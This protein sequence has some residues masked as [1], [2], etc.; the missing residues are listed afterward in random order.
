MSKLISEITQFKQKSTDYLQSKAKN[1]L[2]QIVQQNGNY[3]K[4][5]ADSDATAAMS[6]LNKLADLKASKNTTIPPYLRFGYLIAETNSGKQLDKIPIPLLL[7]NAETAAVLFDMEH[8]KPDDIPALFQHIALR[9]LLSLQMKVCRFYMIDTDFGSSFSFFSTV[10]NPSLQRELF[11]KSEDINKLMN[12]LQKTVSQANQ[13]YLG[14][15]KNLTDYNSKAGQMAQP[16]HFVFIDDFPNAFTSQSLESLY[17]LIS[18]GNAARAGIHIFINYS[19]K[20][21]A[22]RDFDINRF[23]Q[24][25]ACVNANAKGD[26]SL[27]NWNIKIPLPKYKTVIET[28]LPKN[29]NKIVDFINNMEEEKI[30][31]SLD[32]WIDDLKKQKQIWKDTTENGI[33]VP[34]GFVSP[35]EMFNF[36]LAND[37]D[38]NCNDFFALVA[39]RP[40][41]G[42]TVLLHN[43]IVN[44]CMK[45]ASDELNLYLADFAEGASFSIY[46][47]LPHCKSLMLSNNK[48]YALRMLEHLEKEFK[49]RSHLYQQAQKKFG[50]QVNT[51]TSYRKITGE[52]LPRILLVMD[53]F[54]FLFNSVDMV[55]LT[56]RE[57]LCN[58]IRQW[59]K[60]GISIILCTQDLSGVNF[61]DADSKITYRFAL[62]LLEMD[63]KRVIRN[64]AAMSLTRKGQTIMNNT[65]NG[66]EQMN[67]EFQCAFT[68]RYLEHTNWLAAGYKK[69]FGELPIKYICES[70]TDADITDNIALCQ[71]IENESFT[72]NHNYCDVFVGKPDLLRD[73]HTRIRYRRQQNSNTLMIGEDFGTAINTIA[74]SLIQLQKQSATSSKLYVIDCFNAGDEFQGALNGLADY[75]P[76]NFVLGNAQVIDTIAEELEKRKQANSAGT[77]TEERIVL[78]VLNIQNC[79]DLKPQ[80]GGMMPMPSPAATKLAKIL[81]DGAPLGI[82]CI[83]HSLN[84]NSL[85]GNGNIFDS[86][87]MNN[88]ENK[89][90]LKGADTQTM[91]LGGTKIG[92]VE[93]NN[94][95]IVQN[96]KLDGENYEQCKAYSEITANKSNAT[97]DFISQLFENNRYA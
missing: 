23:K 17:N 76:D 19:K 68:P 87:V 72:I 93:E 31:F 42:K 58:G 83:I 67:V 22:P 12:D 55:S 85:V 3:E 14:T 51:L 90:F 60:C 77:F 73:S 40:G 89:I 18:N 41:Y 29:A 21:N 64:N 43:V 5:I 61:G 95:M 49:N 39:G 59:R 92:T 35:T 81:N 74:T 65:A 30:V 54:H 15:H 71:N 82:H 10:N 66:N 20:N 84:Y 50:Q 69:N 70:G 25:C 44:S 9:Y 48:E 75:A 63:S 80:G 94:I 27:S 91:F 53:E 46:R 26:V 45:Y 56:A 16:Y 8:A 88:F 33:K 52:K 62:N 79:Y 86:K 34:V 47:D 24:I 13:S 36:Y 28:T 38:S 1:A 11:Y 4:F 37:N 32:A 78:A 57:K 6:D 96:N 97:I 2:L 7:P